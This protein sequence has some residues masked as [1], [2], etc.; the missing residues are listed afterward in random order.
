MRLS[1][2]TGSSGVLAAVLLAFP[3]LLFAAQ[4]FVKHQNL[5]EMVAEAD[6]IYRGQ[7]ISINTG[8]L[9]ING[10]SIPTA[11]YRILVTDHFKGEVDQQKG[12]QKVAEL[13][14]V[15]THKKFLSVNGDLA[16]MPVL[17]DLPQ[18]KIGEE[19]LLLTNA[20][21]QYG[22]SNTIGLGQGYFQISFT[23]DGE[24]C[25]N[26]LDNLGLFKSMGVSMPAKGPVAYDDLAALIRAEMATGGQ[27]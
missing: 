26:Q 19:Y 6:R 12:E 22:L 14:V 13:R 1:R 25:A 24:V 3:G 7:V 23:D 5:S 18:L 17:P 8:D 10:A 11:T 16:S 4:A 15:G 27:Q 9:E 20:P 2:L 21:N